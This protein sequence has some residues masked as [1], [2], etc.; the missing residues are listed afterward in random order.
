MCYLVNY[1]VSGK[2]SGIRFSN[3]QSLSGYPVKT[4]TGTALIA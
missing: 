3:V 2:L 4:L 1:P